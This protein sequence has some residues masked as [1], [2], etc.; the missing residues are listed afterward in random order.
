V[1]CHPFGIATD[2]PPTGVVTFL[3]TDIEGSTRLVRQLRDR[4]NEVLTEHQSLLRTAFAAHGGHELDTEGDSFFVAFSSAREAVLAAVEG[5]LS[6]V[7]HSWLDGV[8]VKVRMGIHTG[9]AVGREGQYTGLAVHRAARICAA[10][11]GGQVLVSQATQTLLEDE[12]ED[13]EISL[14]DLGEHRLKDFDRPVRLY[15]AGAEGLPS[16]FPVLQPSGAPSQAVETAVKRPLWRRRG[17]LAATALA[18][19]ALLAA[20]V[21]IWSRSAGGGDGEVQPNHV[22]VIDPETNKVVA[23]VGV[24]SDPGPVATGAGSIWVGNLDDRTITRISLGRRVPTATVPLDARTPTGL[25]FGAGALWVAHGLRGQLSRVDRRSNRVTRTIE[26]ADPGSTR[27]AVAVGAGSVWVV[28]GDSTLA[29]VDPRSPADFDATYVGPSPAGVA[30]GSGSVWVVNSGDSTV[31]RLNPKT[32]EPV[33]PPIRVGRRPVGIAFGEGAV[34]VADKGADA[35][36]R[37]DPIPD[38]TKSIPVGAGAG[39]TAVA[40]GGGLVWVANT[41]AGTVSRIDPV[42]N[43]VVETINVGNAPSGIAFGGDAVWVAVQAP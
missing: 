17:V 5:Q 30:V 28:F 8:Q 35:V 26:I 18:L 43:E 7:S 29:W 15:Q 3:F 14:R 39:P 20:A 13:L 16:T 6:L 41:A 36:T 37:I 32:Y 9:Q 10:G 11:H 27:G 4:Y 21:V 38:S 31:T 24:G 1:P 22:G 33:G 23:E 34:W 12:E 25:A 19:A 2:R 40:V 42:R